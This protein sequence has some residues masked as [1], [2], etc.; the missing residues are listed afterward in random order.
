M[1]ENLDLYRDAPIWDKSSIEDAT[2]DWFKCL[3][4]N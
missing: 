1:L 2:K 4:G 3:G